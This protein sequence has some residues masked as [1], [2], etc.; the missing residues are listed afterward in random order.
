MSGD[1]TGRLLGGRYRVT[2]TLGRGGM[3][4]VCKAVDEVLG[5]EVAVKVLRAY[6]DSS[7]PELADLRIRMQREARAAAR[8][9]HSGV[10][11]V[12]DVTEESGLPVIVMELIE[13]RSLDDLIDERGVVEPLEAAAIGAKVADAL[14][15]GH[16]AGVLHRDV[17]PGN[18]LLDHD[19][20]VVLTDFGIAS[21]EAP[22][23]DATTKLTRSGELIG[24]LDYLAP[25]RAQGQ[26]PGPA[27]DIWALGMTLYA[28]VEGSSPFRRTSVWSTLTAIVTEPLPEPRRAGPLTPVLHAMMDKDPAARPSA[29]QARVMLEAV[30]AGED[31]QAAAGR[32]GRTPTAPDVLGAVAPRSA[33]TGDPDGGLSVDPAFGPAASPAG[34]PA[35]RP[36][37]GSSAGPAFGPAGG[38]FGSSPAGPPAGSSAGLAGDPAVSPPGGPSAGP[39]LGPAGGSPLGS[40]SG[41]AGG[42]SGG[43]P[44]GSPGGQFGGPAFGPSEGSPVGSSLGS[45]AGQASGPPADPSLGSSGGPAASPSG[46]QAADPSGGPWSTQPQPPTPQPSGPQPSAAQPPIPPSSSPLPSSAPPG[47]GPPQVPGEPLVSGGAPGGAAPARLG[48]KKALIAAMAVAVLL[49]GGGV[50]YALVGDD[51]DKTAAGSQEDTS[52]SPSHSASPDGGKTGDKGRTDGK[53]DEDGRGDKGDKGGKKTVEP[54]GS[55]SPSASGKPG[56]SGN[57]ASGGS[58]D[59]S[60][61]GKDG[62]GGGGDGASG[63]G[64]GG[65]HG[66]AAGGGGAGG[67][68]ADPDPA[69]VCHDAGGGK[70]NCEV[71]RA[72]TSYTASGEPVGTLNQGLNYFYCQ[73]NLGRRETYGKWTN[74]WWAKTDDDS[75][76]TN[77]FISDVY[78]K[79]GDNDQ[80]LPGLPVC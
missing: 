22:G 76:H 69:P 4:V 59:D 79:G 46:G 35:A 33:R 75:G 37:G 56:D 23:D 71:W 68:S 57:G 16:H 61:G 40:P 1:L 24:S 43:S 10:I 21:M 47:F 5:R 73:Q 52:A 70:Y 3:G 26:E 63:G 15:A 42:Q 11:T 34:D 60:D 72:A 6:T 50:T 66:S 14:G 38:Q 32:A 74:V 48:R 18:V 12:H 67:G 9:R 51:G 19:G 41:P 31:P 8:I 62:K 58:D 27:S 25:E 55:G 29:G 65:D 36:P 2:G 20:R 39:V 45:S 53:D 7:G 49:A 28:A 80:P 44:A 30:A 54:S 77:V 64:G 13:G 78:I 17:K